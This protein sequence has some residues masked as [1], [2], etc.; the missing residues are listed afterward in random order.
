MGVVSQSVPAGEGCAG[1]AAR[2]RGGGREWACDGEA[3]H[4]RGDGES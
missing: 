1:P 3:P 2:G 4:L